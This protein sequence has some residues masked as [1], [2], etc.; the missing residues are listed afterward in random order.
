MAV[1]KTNAAEERKI[2]QDVERLAKAIR[3]KDVSGV[4]ALYATDVLCFDLVAPL[5]RIGIDS[6]RRRAEE[7]FSSFDGPIRYQVRD[8]RIAAAEDVAFYTSLN[9]VDGTRTDGQPIKMWIRITAGCRKIAG[10][11]K[12]THEHV[13]VP[14]DMQSMKAELALRP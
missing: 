12:I 1:P 5:Q 7:W 10:A 6:V 8:L 11:W 2:R 14:F 9:E 3:A 4:M 13:S